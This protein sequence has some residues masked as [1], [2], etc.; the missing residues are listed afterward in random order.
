MQFVTLIDQFTYDV[1]N[2]IVKEHIYYISWSFFICVRVFAAKLM[3]Y[4]SNP[5]AMSF[6]PSPYLRYIVHQLQ[7]ITNFFEKLFKTLLNSTCEIE[8]LN[9]LQQTRD[10][11]V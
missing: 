9:D 1:K 3:R 8:W 10:G 7:C 11:R 6:P 5:F 2:E 4:D